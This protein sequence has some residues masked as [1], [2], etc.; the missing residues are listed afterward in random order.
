M[1]NTKKSG[2]VRSGDARAASLT[3]K[4]RRAI[5]ASGGTVTTRRN[6]A[7]RVLADA[8]LAY[9]GNPANAER[10][11]LLPPDVADAMA[12]YRAAIGD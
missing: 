12:A 1:A 4:R 9:I 3:A 10:A 8:L 6:R 5:A 2:K 11:A 7:A